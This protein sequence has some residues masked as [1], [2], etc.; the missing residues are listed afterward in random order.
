MPRRGENIYKRK[1]GRWEGRR[2]KKD[3]KYQYFY[4]QT[5]KGVKEKMKNSPE[6]AR[7][8][9]KIL[10]DGSQSAA[11][12]F[13]KWLED[14]A[15]RVKPSTFESYYR[16]MS[17]YVIP[18]YE[19]NLYNH[20]TEDSVIRFTKLIREETD[21]ADSS[22]KKNLTIFKIA[23]KEILKN[24]PQ[25]FSIIEL[26][27][28]PKPADKEVEVFSMK[29]QRLI[30]HTAL[31]YGDKRAIGII[32]CFYTGIR[33]GELC[34]LKWKDI[35]MET[36]TLTIKRTVSRV[37]NFEEEE[38]EKT[39]LFVGS[40]K[41]RK[42]LRKIPLPGFLLNMLK[43][44]STQSAED[45]YILSRSQKPYDPRRFQ[46]LYKRILKKAAV[47]DRKFHAIRHT[48]ATRALELGVDIKTIS[49]LLG[50]SSVSITLNVY[51]HSL[52]EQKKAA[53]DKFNNLYYLNEQ[54]TGGMVLDSSSIS[55][56]F[57]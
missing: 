39:V 7:P 53:I 11:C 28:P 41:S 30:E 40:P 32:L 2:L 48:F 45:Y 9:K 54:D 43:E 18:F 20:I 46:K 36:G 52:M 17:K 37:R 34:A 44:G 33:L 13:E 47:T 49:E 6:T 14:A 19:S 29:D 26:I 16:C 10:T 27:K 55:K 51:A 31:N 56:Q 57:T 25:C 8:A 38:E 42:S 21:L 4:A 22:K 1:D 12:L 35:D 5:Y 3:G 23:L 24:S 50:H 15:P